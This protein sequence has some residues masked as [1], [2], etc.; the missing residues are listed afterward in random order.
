M[1]DVT[2]FLRESLLIEGIDRD[3]T[4]MEVASFEKFMSGPLTVDAVVELQEHVAP[5][6]PLRTKFNRNVRVGEYVAPPGGPGIRRRLHEL[7]AG[8]AES[9]WHLH[10]RFEHLHPFEDGNGRVGRAVWAWDVADGGGDPLA[11]GFLAWW[12]RESASRGHWVWSRVHRDP[13]GFTQLR[14]YYY[15]VLRSLSLGPPLAY[16]IARGVRGIKYAD[17]PDG[18]EWPSLHSRY[19]A[20]LIACDIGLPDPI[21][22]RRALRVRAAR[23]RAG[24]SPLD[25]ADLLEMD[26]VDYLVAE[27][28]EALIPAAAPAIFGD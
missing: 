21:T 11:T 4:A 26:V 9:S 27:T 7:L 6:R 1:P 15:H 16:Q 17:P 20:R 28:G 5:A 18:R 2:A 14:E 24:W 8:G 3:P 10:A 22:S 25:A 12:A 13:A 23:E 19:L